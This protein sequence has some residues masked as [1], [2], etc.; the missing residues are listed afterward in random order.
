MN[1]PE[2]PSVRLSKLMSERGI[3]SRREADKYIEA[4]QV[5]VDGEIVDTLG[6][7]VPSTAKISLLPQARRRQKEKVTIILNKPLGYVSSQPEKGYRAA[8]ELITPDNQ[9]EGPASSELNP[10][11]KKGLSVAGRLDI[12]ST[13]LLIFT[14]D[15]SLV[16]KLIG[17][18]ADLEK[19]YIVRVE[20]EIT[21]DTLHQ[22]RYGLALDGKPLKK[23]KIELMDNQLLRFVLREGKKRQI[24]RMCELVGL[25]VAKLKRVRVGKL[26]LGKLPK[27]CW[28]YLAADEKL[29]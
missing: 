21:E 4:G 3:C 19:E 5:K 10:S 1:S 22:L 15:G 2:Q 26:R 11:H 6:S 16:K 7:K 12:D 18:D 14:Q 23:A 17:P 28:R 9:A 13:G 24:R 20:G 27:G 29:A 8:I 25:K